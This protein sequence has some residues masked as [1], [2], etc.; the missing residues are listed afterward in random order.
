MADKIFDRAFNKVLAGQNREEEKLEARRQPTQQEVEAEEAKALRAEALPMSTQDA[1]KRMVLADRDKDYFRLLELADPHVD[2]R[3]KVAWNCT[4]S[5][6]S[7][8]YRKLSALVHPDKNPHPDARTAF[9][10]L[11]K[12]HRLLRDPGTLEETLNEQLGA[13]KLRQEAAEAAATPEERIIMNAAKRKQAQ[14]LQKEEAKSYKT[15]VLQQTLRLQE[16]AKRK[17]EIVERA[18]RR[19]VKEESSEEEEELVVKRRIKPTGPATKRKPK[20]IF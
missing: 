17:R 3:G 6:V 13:A 11:N 20:L 2:A 15:E 10:A 9:E 5:D 12:A 4:P 7:K 18:K 16:R 19:E 1:I 8:A 14:Q